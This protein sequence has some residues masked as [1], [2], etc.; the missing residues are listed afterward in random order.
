MH[1]A[2]SHRHPSA[3][4]GL[5][6]K[7]TT[8]T[9]PVEALHPT[10]A[11]RE[12]PILATH[13]P[14]FPFTENEPPVHVRDLQLRRD[15][16][17]LRRLPTRVTYELLREIGRSRGIQ[18]IIENRAAEFAGIDPDQLTATGGDQFAPAPIN[19]VQP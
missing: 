1:V 5:V 16:E 3:R 8:V 4:H 2:S 7:T 6:T 15:V 10:R 14:G 11:R 9:A 12:F 17:R 18:T 13:W 19:R